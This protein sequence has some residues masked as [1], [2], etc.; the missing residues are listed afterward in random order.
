MS[1]CERRRS[2]WET[3]RSVDDAAGLARKS[4]DPT[5]A[6]KKIMVTVI[7]DFR[8]FT[9]GF[10]WFDPDDLWLTD[11]F[12]QF[13]SRLK[14]ERNKL[15]DQSTQT[16][17]ITLYFGFFALKATYG[18]VEKVW[19]L[20]MLARL[21]IILLWQLRDLARVKIVPSGRPARVWTTQGS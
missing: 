1:S 8:I 6:E 3:D 14:I 9:I 18:E 17:I 11:L 13:L 16:E 2:C 12:I 21:L 19:W 20:M 5:A 10:C 15:H 7:C 4:K